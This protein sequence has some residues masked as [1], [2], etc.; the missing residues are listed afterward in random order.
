[1][2]MQQTEI[3]DVAVLDLAG[4]IDLFNAPDLRDRLNKLIAE[5]RSR[6]ILNMDKVSYID[7]SGI[8]ALISGMTALKKVGG[9]LR[10]TRVSVAV[11][12]V[13]DLMRLKTVLPVFASED[14]AMNSFGA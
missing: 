12:R 3:G 1:M 14:D 13:F 2:K 8:G 4:E 6:I 5:K 11:G 10:L 7:S 9:A